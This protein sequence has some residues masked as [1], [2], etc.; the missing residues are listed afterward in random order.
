MVNYLNILLKIKR[1]EIAEEFRWESSRRRYKTLFAAI[2]QY[3]KKP[4]NWGPDFSDIF[5]FMI[6]FWILMVRLTKCF[7]I[8]ACFQASYWWKS[9]P[10]L[11]LKKR[12][13]HKMWRTTNM[14]YDTERK[15]SE[16]L[17]EFL[18]IVI[19]E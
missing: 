14:S 5:N 10:F 16:M 1:C 8:F 15:K 11:L 13:F 2:S 17:T 12:L 4:W 19:C 6:N 3:R 7:L 9:R 18:G